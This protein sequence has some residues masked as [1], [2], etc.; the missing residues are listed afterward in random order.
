M[1]PFRIDPLLPVTAVKTYQAVMPLATHFR[2]AT[3]EESDCPH[4]LFGW[5]TIV[6]A[7]SPQA[8][9]IRHD[10]GRGF[11]ETRHPDGLAEFVFE[12]GQTCF[13]SGRHQLPNGRPEVFIE[14]DGD[15]R[16]NPTG[17]R[18]QHSP[19]GW[20]GSFGEHQERIHD[21]LEKG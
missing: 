16:G 13:A 19:D 14:R 21:A 4:Y 1:E 18:I 9:Y 17:R 20:L 5:K 15:W 11:T 7:D 3:C 12:A 8:H 10:S 6:P 2:P